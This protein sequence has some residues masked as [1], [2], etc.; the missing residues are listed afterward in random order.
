MKKFSVFILGMI[1]GISCIFAQD[2]PEPEKIWKI[3][4]INQLN[5]NQIALSNWAAGGDPSISFGLVSKWYANYKKDKISWDNNLNMLFG[6]FKEEGERLKK[7]D[8]MLD[9]TSIFGYEAAKKWEYS[10]MLNFRSQFY[11]G[12]DS[13]YDSVK[14]SNFMAPGYLTIS[15][16]MRYRPVDWFYIL[17]SPITLKSVF[18]M[19]QDL[20]D[21]GAF[22]VDPAE[23][24]TATGVK[25]KD[26][27]NSWL[28]YG[29][30]A[31]AYI[32][33][34]IVKGLSFESK[35]NAFYSYNDREGLKGIDMDINWE[36]FLNYNLNDWFSVNL[37]VHLIYYP[38]QPPVNVVILEGEPVI[39]AGDSYKRQ[40]KQ[41]FG[42]GLT[43]KFA[44]FKEE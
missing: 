3:T 37:F 19:D 13:D 18:V 35:L 2:D 15:P 10:L 29:A 30:F 26:G 5:L 16:A 40:I 1:F 23:Y 20:A 6:L 9:L 4:G 25:T 31:E 32:G 43:Y 36:N 42:F 24:D 17:L 7:S 21:I 8:D 41:T 28:R 12:V 14:V 33:K 38:G 39:E 44:N 27:E 34:E 22:G 11:K